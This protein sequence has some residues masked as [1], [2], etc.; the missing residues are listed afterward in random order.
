MLKRHSITLHHII[1]VHNDMFDHMD[2]LMRSLAMKK[3]QSQEDVFCAMRFSRQKLSKYYIEVTAMTGLHPMWA[4]ILDRFWK[5]DRIGSGTRVSIL[6]L[7]TIL[8]IVPNRTRSFSVMWR[9][10]TA[11]NID[12]GRSLNPKSYLTTISSPPQWLLDLV[13]LL[14]LHMICPVMIKNT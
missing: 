13:N 4:H 2:G 12:I 14:L 11:L 9:T 10:T 3:I 8:H 6:T 7:E 5:W 1:N